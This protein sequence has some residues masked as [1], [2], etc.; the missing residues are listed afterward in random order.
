MHDANFSTSQNHFLILALVCRFL[1][2]KQASECCQDWPQTKLCPCCSPWPSGTFA[3]ICSFSNEALELHCVMTEPFTWELLLPLSV[4]L[5]DFVYSLFTSLSAWLFVPFRGSCAATCSYWQAELAEYFFLIGLRLVYREENS[6]TQPCCALSHL[7]A[8]KCI[9]KGFGWRMV[10]S[11]HTWAV[12]SGFWVAEERVDEPFCS[13]AIWILP[14]CL[15]VTSLQVRKLIRFIK[16]SCLFVWLSRLIF[17]LD[18]MQFVVCL[19]SS[20]GRKRAVWLLWC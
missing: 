17:R 19:W 5:Q 7:W 4:S 13:F 20:E 14:W 8:M 3:F 12:P 18:V 1:L 10:A 9:I 16:L 11:P 2:Q 15:D 6:Q